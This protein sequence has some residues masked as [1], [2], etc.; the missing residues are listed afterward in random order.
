MRY[1]GVLRTPPNVN[2]IE[3]NGPLLDKSQCPS[4]GKCDLHKVAF[5]PIVFRDFQLGAD[6]HPDFDLS[7][8]KDFNYYCGRPDLAS[9]L[10]TAFPFY[11]EC[12]N[13]NDGTSGS[14]AGKSCGYEGS[15][16][17]LRGTFYPVYM[18][19]LA[20]G[21]VANTL[22]SFRKPF[23]YEPKAMADKWA[24]IFPDYSID[25]TSKY[26][27]LF[28]S[29]IVSPAT[30]ATWYANVHS[31]EVLKDPFPRLKNPS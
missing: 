27:H 28:R 29:S 20:Q 8:L 18:K 19:G 31:L 16:T 13:N 7:S 6:G 2:L 25:E 5:L 11:C 4:V 24:S 10:L 22:S 14:Q 12:F 30:F 9:K 15:E 23:Y 3:Q 17:I 21:M 26:H 1:L